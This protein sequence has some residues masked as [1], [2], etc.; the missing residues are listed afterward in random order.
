[1]AKSNV[2]AT[3]QD[4][5]LDSVRPIG[6]FCSALPCLLYRSRK[7]MMAAAG[8]DVSSGCVQPSFS[9]TLE[10]GTSNRCLLA[11]EKPCFSLCTH[12]R[13]RVRLARLAV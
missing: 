7:R 3:G 2:F 5:G 8:L 9:R 12:W 4:H 1:M 13:S 11:Q 6:G 10:V